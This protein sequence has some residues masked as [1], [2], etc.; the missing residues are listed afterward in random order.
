MWRTRQR[1]PVLRED[2]IDAPKRVQ[3]TV[4]VETLVSIERFPDIP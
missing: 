3:T 1:L 4:P 2:T